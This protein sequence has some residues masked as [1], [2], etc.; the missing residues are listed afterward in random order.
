MTTLAGAAAERVGQLRAFVHFCI[1]ERIAIC[2]SDA[3]SV[4]NFTA[5]LLPSS[6]RSAPAAGSTLRRPIASAR[7]TFGCTPGA[8]SVAECQCVRFRTELLAS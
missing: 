6:P 3:P 1:G 8:S 2:N 4:F 7:S 5:S